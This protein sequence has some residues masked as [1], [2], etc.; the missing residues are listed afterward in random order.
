MRYPV[1]E[2]VKAISQGCLQHLLAQV[3][4]ETRGLA[5][6]TFSSKE[7]P[8][9]DGTMS[10]PGRNLSQY[11][12]AKGPTGVSGRPQQA[13]Q[14]TGCC[15]A[16]PWAGGGEK[17]QKQPRACACKH[18]SVKVP[19][20][21]PQSLSR[22]GWGGGEGWA[23]RRVR[24]PRGRETETQRERW[25]HGRRQ[26]DRRKRSRED[27]ERERGGHRQGGGGAGDEGGPQG[28]RQT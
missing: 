21:G 14:M 19:P 1:G 24:T 26:T 6:Q 16:G 18:C 12:A 2:E 3:L 27:S 13:R 4:E 10:S 7:S 20:S 8:L 28:R 15:L 22:L 17:S 11:L 25:R 9:S 5:L 23:G